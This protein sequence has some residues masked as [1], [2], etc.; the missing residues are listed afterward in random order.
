M[1]RFLLL[2]PLMLCAVSLQAAE[3]HTPNFTVSCADADLA[4]QIGDTAEFYRK[5]HARDWLGAELPKWFAPCPVRVRYGQIGAGGATTFS[6]EQGQVSGW[7]MEIQGPRDRLIDS[8]VPHEVLHTIFACKFRRPLPRWADEGAATYTEA[9]AERK[10]YRD[11]GLQVVGTREHIPLSELLAAMEYPQDGRRQFLFY[12][13]SFVLAE[14]LLDLKGRPEYVSFL[15]TYFKSGSWETAFAKH[16][17]QNP[18]EAYTGAIRVSKPPSTPVDYNS[19][20]IDIFVQDNCRPCDKFKAEELPKLLKAKNLKLRILDLDKDWTWERAKQDGIN[21]T[22]SFIVYRNEKRQAVLQGLHT[23]EQLLAECKGPETVKVAQGIGIG[24]FGPV[25]G[26]RNDN[27]ANPH[28]DFSPAQRQLLNETIDQRAQLAIDG[29]I[30]NRMTDLEK[31]MDSRIKN[32][33]LEIQSKLTD[34]QKALINA[35]S[36]QKELLAGLRG[37]IDAVEAGKADFIKQHQEALAAEQKQREALAEEVKAAKEAAANAQTVASDAQSE[38]LT[39]KEK[40]ASLAKEGVKTA[41]SG[42]MTS[43]MGGNTPPAIALTL[44]GTIATFFWNRRKK[45]EIAKQPDVTGT[46]AGK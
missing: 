44:I 30:S 39:L 3:Y 36:G 23:A 11:T 19:Y 40:L 25:G 10:N 32:A 21:G 12:G 22:P 14:Y 41:A 18:G 17:G 5:Q 31:L 29:T 42:F 16:Y 46:T 8:V 2:I 35:T 20:H 26:A 33:I 7:R 9:E 37:Q 1:K 38:N 43:A 27:R 6:F 45:E 13:Q 28:Q 24:Y 15:D 4:K 34:E